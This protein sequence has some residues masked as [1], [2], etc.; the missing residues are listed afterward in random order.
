MPIVLSESNSSIREQKF[1]PSVQMF[2]L[3][4]R[5]LR[6]KQKKCWSDC[7]VDIP[8]KHCFGGSI[9]SELKEENETVVV[10]VDNEGPKGT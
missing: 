1:L 3:G 6:R 4:L 10:F 2:H 9:H 8:S 5:H 7:E